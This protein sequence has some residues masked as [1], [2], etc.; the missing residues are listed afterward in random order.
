VAFV[1]P[2][3][4]V[5]FVRPGEVIYAPLASTRLRVLLPA[6]WLAR[7]IDVCIVP[8]EWL[9]GGG[10]LE[11]LG[12]VA[13]V[14][15]KL[16]SG[17][18]SKR[19]EL[20][21]AISAWLQDAADRVRLVADI[22]DNYAALGQALAAPAMRQLQDAFLARCEVIVPTAALAE[23]LERAC[24]HQ[25]RVIEDPFESPRARPW[26]K[27]LG[28]PL[29]L[30]WFGNLGEANR[31]WLEGSFGRLA[32]DLRGRLAELTIVT[33]PNGAEWVHT[34]RQRIGASQGSLALRFVPWT[35]DATW[36][37]ID[38]CDAAFLPQDTTSPWTR[39]KSH[40]RLV[41]VIRGGRLALAS[42]IPSY[43]EL[44]DFAWVK[45]DAVA[46]I[47][48]ALANP[49]L[50]R[51]RIEAGQAYVDRRFSP[52]AVAAKWASVLGLKT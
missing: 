15:A 37:A 48:W 33:H 47:D 49:E 24:T 45:A 44:A 11:V 25:V 43:L 8:P 3:D 17:L 9:L 52:Q 12:P 27:P 22:S 26:R 31:A 5:R 34:L 42:P 4:R 36:R 35:L 13:V 40:N 10:R 41:E 20:A 51:R 23:D 39:G 7:E 28:G 32:R 16:G 19:P 50:A 6:A 1:T 2:C 30:L 21:A 29:R 14:F 38:E 18:L 46:G